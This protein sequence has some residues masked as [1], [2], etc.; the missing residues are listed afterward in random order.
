MTIVSAQDNSLATPYP[1]NQAKSERDYLAV[2]EGVINTLAQRA[3][4]MKILRQLLPYALSIGE[5]EMGALLVVGDQANHLTVVVR[6]GLPDEVLQQLTLGDL[7]RDLL[8][9]H[10]LHLTSGSLQLNPRQALLGR[11]KLKYLFALPLRFYKDV[12]GAIVVATRHAPGNVLSPEFQHRLTILAQLVAL[13]LD[14]VRLRTGRQRSQS[15]PLPILPLEQEATRELE[16]LLAAVMSAEE[17]VVHQNKD[18]GLL[19]T[20]SREVGSVLQLNPLLEAALKQTKVALNVEAAWVYFNENGLLVLQAHNGLSETY[21]RQMQQLKPGDGAE[22]MALSRREP[23]LRDALLFHSGRARTVVEAEKL[24]AIA[25]VPLLSPNG[26]HVL[27]VLAIGQ[28]T[29]REW[30]GRDK[31]MLV[32]ISRQVAQ[33]LANSW[34][35]H[36]AQQKVE[37]WEA[38]Y[39]AIE[40]SNAQLIARANELEKQVQTLRQAEQQIWTALAASS[41]ARHR[42]GS[43]KSSELVDDQLV[44]TLKKAL[45]TL[46]KPEEV[47]LAGGKLDSVH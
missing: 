18:L 9:G 20:L 41:Q 7:G 24:R 35:F 27:G 2:M 39:S 43:A 13:F 47:Q 15:K 34:M 26:D 3:D 31:H 45:D 19:N 4:K 1:G 14:D 25:A 40:Q 29:S 5:V 37:T 17:E 46:V 33:A 36:E 30:S 28:Y 16:D 21:V 6:Q 42:H 23:I 32:S 12:L 38:K 10:L 11:H 8:A 22:G 44:A